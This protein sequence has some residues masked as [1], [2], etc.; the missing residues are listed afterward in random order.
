MVKDWAPHK[1]AAAFADSASE[2]LASLL[3]GCTPTFASAACESWP[4]EQLA[5][6]LP[7]LRTK[8]ARQVGRGAPGRNGLVINSSGCAT[9]AC[10]SVGSSKHGS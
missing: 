2:R 4:P 8:A 10:H 3:E 7:L 9:A 5:Q 6:V 1:F